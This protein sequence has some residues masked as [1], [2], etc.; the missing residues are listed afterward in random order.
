MTDAPT[1]KCSIKSCE[2]NADPEALITFKDLGR[3]PVCPRHHFASLMVDKDWGTA[4][5]FLKQRLIN[6]AKMPT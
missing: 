4:C 1:T 3:Q 2:R 6:M 5:A